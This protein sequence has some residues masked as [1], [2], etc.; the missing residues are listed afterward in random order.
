MIVQ[1]VVLFIDDLT[2]NHWISEF[3]M[4]TTSYFFMC[5]LLNNLDTGIFGVNQNFAFV[6]LV[7]FVL[8]NKR[9]LF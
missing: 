7:F 8:P 5:I 4:Y 2:N 9:R 3:F 1:S 6:L